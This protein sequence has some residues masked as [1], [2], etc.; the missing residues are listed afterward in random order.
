MAQR[1][2]RRTLATRCATLTL[3][4]QLTSGTPLVPHRH[5]AFAP[6]T[7]SLFSSP[8]WHGLT[9]TRFSPTPRKAAWH[10][11]I[12]DG[13]CHTVCHTPYT[14]SLAYTATSQTDFARRNHRRTAA[15]LTTNAGKRNK[16]QIWAVHKMH[17]HDSWRKKP[18]LAR[19]G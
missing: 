7:T 1:H 11:D 13:L 18:E 19:E 6:A 3:Y 4:T 5:A 8:Q 15:T 12:T 10:S 9:R 2:H 14:P 16:Y 17:V